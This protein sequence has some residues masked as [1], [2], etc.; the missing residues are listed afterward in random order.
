MNIMSILGSP[1]ANGNTAGVLDYVEQTWRA[2][3]HTVDHAH[4]M[5]QPIAGCSEC[6]ACKGGGAAPC[7]I[8]DFGKVLLRRMLSADLV[9]LAAPL[10]CWNFP[11]ETKALIDRMYSFTTSGA[12]YESLIDGKSFALLMT[13]A[14]PEKDNA[15]IAIIAFDRLIEYTRAHRAGCL[16]VTGCGTPDKLPAD[17]EARAIAFAEKLVGD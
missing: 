6:H 15:D 1:R 12:Q 8:D 5:E 2:A 10:F 3:G 11:S 7:A 9:L 16:L 14:G 4:V 17:A 13:A